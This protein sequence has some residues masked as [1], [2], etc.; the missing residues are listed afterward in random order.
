MTPTQAIQK[1]GSVL[2]VAMPFV[3]TGL[4]VTVG[5][6][7]W[8]IQQELTE[9]K[10]LTATVHELQLFQAETKANRYTT[11]DALSD[12]RKDDDMDEARLQLIRD[13]LRAVEDLLPE[14]FPPRATKEQIDRLI[15]SVDGI[16]EIVSENQVSIGRLETD[17]IVIKSKLN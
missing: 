11:G 9:V 8:F 3:N 5:I 10:Q 17:M 12:R 7:A 15:I 2:N 1:S 16:Q 14:S 6:I 4:A 13:R